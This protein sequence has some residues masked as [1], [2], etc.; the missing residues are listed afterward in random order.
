MRQLLCCLVGLLCIGGGAGA[1]EGIHVD[2]AA[3]AEARDA[4]TISSAEHAIVARDGDGRIVWWVDYRDATP[5]GWT[6]RD[7]GMIQLDDGFVVDRQGNAVAYAPGGGGSPEARRSRSGVCPMW[8]ALSQLSTP[9][10]GESNVYCEPVFDSAGNAWVFY[11]EG[12]GQWTVLRMRR[13]Y[14][15][16][17]Y[18]TGATPFAVRLH[19]VSRMR[20]VIDADD[21]ITLLFREVAGDEYWL[22]ALR[23]EAGVGWA[24]PVR[25]VSTLTPFQ[26]I[27]A[28]VNVEGRVVAAIDQGGA[29]VTAV[30]DPANGVWDAPLPAS[31][32]EVEAAIPTV[33]ASQ[34]R[35]MVYLLYVGEI[36]RGDGIYARL[37]DPATKTW[38]PPE[39]LPG[40]EVVRYG[41][42][43]SNAAFPAAF[44]T[45]GDLV[46]FW[47]GWVSGA[48][49]Y[50]SR[51]D[52]GT[53]LS[54]VQLESSYSGA[55]LEIFGSADASTM[56][57]V[58]CVAPLGYGGAN[59]LEVCR[60]RD[61][62]GWS[63]E[64][65]YS[66]VYSTYSRPR[67]AAFFGRQAVVT[68]LAPQDE[69]E[70]LTSVVYDGSQWE[71]ELRDIPDEEWSA[72]YTVADG[73][74]VLL[75]FEANDLLESEGLRASWLRTL[76]ADLTGD[77]R[78]DLED[79]QTLL[80]AYGQNSA[81]DL[82]WDGDTDLADL[83][84]LLGAYG[85]ECG[86]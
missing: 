69:V 22:V 80:A 46:V 75:I 53:W 14:G 41:P 23:Y 28:A 42:V 81:G 7:D 50:G 36:G 51:T 13:S 1:D 16:D 9:A 48:Y 8:S 27:S 15:H 84:I 61:G 59:I 83:Q 33:V 71:S 39:Y 19:D 63:E 5:P 10:A 38:E 20:A 56:G 66:W 6:L 18:W 21:N 57:D 62:A 78:V 67:I 52:N 32:G 70:Q 72:H 74:E 12:D 44:S 11:A 77:G 45:A 60:Y 3:V 25:V 43:F 79:L 55:M 82:D 2:G 34:D 4:M 17:N 64:E 35:E 47:E 54:A 86:G 73:D 76:H 24:E 40:S 65:A 68:Y 37:F 85:D 26:T 49:I 31:Q 29:I 30:F 58:W